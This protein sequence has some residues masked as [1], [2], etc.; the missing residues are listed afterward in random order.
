MKKHRLEEWNEKV[1]ARI[2]QFAP[3]RVATHSGG[4]QLNPSE[5]KINDHESRKWRRF[6]DR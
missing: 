3:V 5:T 1:F 2:I 6:G 4:R